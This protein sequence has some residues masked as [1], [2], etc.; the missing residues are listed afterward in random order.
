MKGGRAGAYMA[1]IKKNEK[2]RKQ[3]ELEMAKHN[4]PARTG[5]HNL[6]SMNKTSERPSS[7]ASRP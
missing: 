2:I 7:S 4:P 1:T 6:P 3:R 5:P